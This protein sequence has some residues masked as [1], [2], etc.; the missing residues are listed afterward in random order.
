ML[1]VTTAVA[2]TAPGVAQE[3][4]PA[5]QTPAPVVLTTPAPVEPVPTIAPNMRSEPV[6][7]PLPAPATEE[8]RSTE[9]ADRAADRA[10]AR[11]AESLNATLAS[12]GDDVTDAEHRCLAQGVYFESKGEPL[13][14][15]LAVAEVIINRARSGRFASSVCGVLTQRGQFSF[16]RGG[17]IPQPSNSQQWRTAVAIA[18]V[19][20]DDAWDSRASNALFFHA[21]RVSPGWNR[22]RVASIGNHVFYR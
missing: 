4:A 20:L 13:E 8:T 6:V 11:R 21:T 12:A 10:R 5:V 19:A 18:R 2:M 22:A 1:S 3:A 14:G 9:R 15:Q 7:Q 16:V 17:R